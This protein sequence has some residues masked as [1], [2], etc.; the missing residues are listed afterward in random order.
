M[1]AGTFNGGGRLEDDLERDYT[2][3]PL[4]DRPCARCGE[5]PMDWPHSICRDCQEQSRAYKQLKRDRT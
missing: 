4:P 1:G 5:Q 2:T 3:A